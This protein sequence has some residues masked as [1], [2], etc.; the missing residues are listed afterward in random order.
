MSE[1]RVAN[2]K[3]TDHRLNR[4]VQTMLFRMVEQGVETKDQV[5][6]QGKRSATAKDRSHDDAHW[7][8][9]MTRDL[10]KRGVWC[11]SRLLAE[12]HGI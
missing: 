10:W 5:A 1:I 7:A 11:V 9:V 6:M 8:I 3:R 2:Q 12:Y 4:A